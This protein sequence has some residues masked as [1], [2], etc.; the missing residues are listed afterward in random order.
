MINRSAVILFKP[1]EAYFRIEKLRADIARAFGG[2][3]ALD[4]PAHL[5]II[6]W[7][8]PQRVRSSTLGKLSLN[9]IDKPIQLGNISVSLEYRAVWLNILNEEVICRLAREVMDD[10]ID[11]GVSINGVVSTNKPHLT[12]AY[13]D[14]D[15]VKL[16]EIGKY[17]N[18]IGIRFVADE[19]IPDKFAICEKATSGKWKL[20]SY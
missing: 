14:Y 6:K 10:L 11:C 8:D 20:A 15:I 9:M 17:C 7:T 13:K 16:H 12:I 3:S 1:N 5:T 19:L 4:L 2:S 18:S